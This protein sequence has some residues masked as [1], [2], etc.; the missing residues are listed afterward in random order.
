L[1]NLKIFSVTFGI[2]GAIPPPPLATRLMLNMAGVSPPQIS[3]VYG[4]SLWIQL[5]GRP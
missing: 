3:I 5:W 2:E 1:I 4:L